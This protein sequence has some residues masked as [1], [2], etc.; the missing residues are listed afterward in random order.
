LMDTPPAPGHDRVLYPGLPEHETE[1]RRR[2]SGIPLHREV[3][4]WFTAI[5][6]E[7]AVAPLETL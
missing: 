7:L 2:A 5:T 4:D 1:Q 6:D 3:I